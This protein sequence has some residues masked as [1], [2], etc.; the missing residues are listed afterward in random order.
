[1]KSIPIVLDKNL[2]DNGIKYYHR[3]K[4]QDYPHILSIGGTGSG[5]T[6][7]NKTIIGKI[8]LRVPDSQI[9]VLDFKGEDYN[10]ANKSN[11]LYMF[12]NCKVGLEKFYS[13]F[14]KRQKGTITSRNLKFLVVEE[15]G[16]MLSFYD[17]K[18][19]EEIKKIIANLV[20]MGRSF[21]VHCLISTQRP[22]AKLFS[23]G[24]RDNFSRIV[25]LGNLS[26]EGKSMLFKD[27]EEKIEPVY[28]QGAGYLL[29]NN[30]DFYRIQVPEVSNVKKLE[31]AIN[32]GLTR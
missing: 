25:A 18:E 5:K 27:F 3:I 1:M 13:D 21:N 26:K 10:F 31:D 14:K 23:S 7:L 9:T 29:I 6:Y 16:S 2:L 19:T 17:R 15:L 28:S 20:L 8:V 11:R 30:S 22:D 4:L 12:E 32:L 24:V